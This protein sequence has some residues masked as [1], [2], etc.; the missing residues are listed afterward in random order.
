[1]TIDGGDKMKQREPVIVDRGSV[2]RD[3]CRHEVATTHFDDEAVVAVWNDND[4]HY[5]EV[6]RSAAEIDA[7]ID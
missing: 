4:S 3:N 5:I 7:F 2:P 1:M 6:F